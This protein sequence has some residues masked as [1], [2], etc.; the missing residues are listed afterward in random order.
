MNRF[1][2]LASALLLGIAA[3]L[4]AAELPV[5]DGLELWLDAAK[6]SEGPLMTADRSLA[7]W[8]D[9]SGHKRHLLQEKFASQPKLLPSLTPDGK[10]PV[11]RFDGQDDSLLLA[12]P[13]KS[14]KEITVFLVAAPRTNAGGFRG[15]LA[16]NKKGVNDYTSGLT[17]DMS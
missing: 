13:G 16:F 17:V 3:S 9:Q 7:T 6:A 15:L 5:K 4:L 10:Q 12:G 11:V 8:R 14:Y 1:V 2:I